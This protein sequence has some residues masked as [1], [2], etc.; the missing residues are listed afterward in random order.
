MIALGGTDGIGEMLRGIAFQYTR[1][2]HQ[3][4]WSVLGAGGWQQV[5]QGAAIG[6]VSGSAPAWLP[7]SEPRLRR[8]AWRPWPQR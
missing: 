8:T 3:S 4:P 1:G 7:S 5:T 2:T 6:L